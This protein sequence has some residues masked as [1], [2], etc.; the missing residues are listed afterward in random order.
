MEKHKLKV[1]PRKI[2]GQKVK[3][4]RKG[5]ILPANI[6]G[7]HIPSI[8]VQVEFKDFEKVYKET[9]ETGLVELLLS[10]EEKARPVLIH[11]VQIHPV[12]SLALH[13]DFYQVDLKEKVT[14]MVPLVLVGVAPAV[15]TKIGVILQT[16]K[17]IEVE[18][19]PGDLPENIEVDISSL[20]EINQEI[21]IPDLKIDPKVTILTDLNLVV[22]KIGSLITKEMEEEILKEEKAAA[23]AAA[24]AEAERVEEAPPGEV[25][26]VVGEEKKED[27]EKPIEEEQK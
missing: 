27:R 6:Y 7:H 18:A 21:K 15:E 2:L 17:E 19:L 12:T 1:E 13:A 25:P 20:K 22:C 23:E 24:A 26:E 4:L 10:G 8:P 9:G 3:K 16:L 14:A 11:N 5:G